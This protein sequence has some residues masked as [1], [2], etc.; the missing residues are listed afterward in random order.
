M[1][2]ISKAPGLFKR[3]AGEPTKDHKAGSTPALLVD[4]ERNSLIGL[5]LCV[6]EISHSIG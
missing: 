5:R 2:Y 1:C 6:N 3:V 4:P